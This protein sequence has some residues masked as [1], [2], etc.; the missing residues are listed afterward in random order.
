MSTSEPVPACVS[1]PVPV[2]PLLIEKVSLRLTVSA[3]LF[4]TAAEPEAVSEPAVAPF[5]TTSEPSEIVTGPSCVTS[6]VMAR[7]PGPVLV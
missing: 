1:E 2:M 6:T 3:P 4:I 5:P 7:V